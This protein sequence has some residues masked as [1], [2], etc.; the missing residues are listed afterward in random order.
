MKRKRRETDNEVDY[1]I[2]NSANGWVYCRDDIITPHPDIGRAAI[3]A[4]NVLGL[5]FGAVD[6]GWNE[7]NQE[8]SV[9]EVN[10]APGLE[11]TTLDKYFEAILARLPQLQGGAFKRRRG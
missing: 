6:V 10:T 2:R 3:R 8:P 11:G 4:V 5:D 9:Y 1:Q 7:H